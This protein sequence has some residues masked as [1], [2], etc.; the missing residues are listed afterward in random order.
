M[1]R[2]DGSTAPPRE[3]AARALT[4]TIA[5]DDAREGIRWLVEVLGFRLATLYDRPDADATLA[6]LIWRGGAVLVA[7]RPWQGPWANTGPVSIALVAED[8][9]AVERH[10]RRAVAAGAEIVRPLQDSSSSSRAGRGRRF[11]LRDPGGHLWTV[12]TF[13]AGACI[14]ATMTIA[15][16][17]RLLA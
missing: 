12:G 4:P 14:E 7:S 2:R 1:R 9:E 16:N 17:D 13:H 8:A 3:H 6:E 5:Y 15:W 10:Y 11:D